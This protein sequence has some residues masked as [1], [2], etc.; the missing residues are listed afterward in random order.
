LSLLHCKCFASFCI[1]LSNGGLLLKLA[2]VNLV[3]FQDFYNFKCQSFAQAHSATKNST[4]VA[5]ICYEK[6]SILKRSLW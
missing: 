5:M 3:L 2:V 4:E 6:D 1:S